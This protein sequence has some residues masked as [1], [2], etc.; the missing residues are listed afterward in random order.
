MLAYNKGVGLRIPNDGIQSFDRRLGFVDLIP[1]LTQS[2][3][4]PGVICTEMNNSD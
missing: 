2:R 4:N 1:V 3:D